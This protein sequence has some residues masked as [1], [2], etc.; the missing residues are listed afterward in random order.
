MGYAWVSANRHCGFQN[1]EKLKF[2]SIYSIYRRNI[3]RLKN[4]SVS[5]ICTSWEYVFIL[6][7]IMLPRTG[8]VVASAFHTH[9]KNFGIVLLLWFDNVIATQRQTVSFDT[10]AIQRT[11]KRTVLS[12][13]ARE[14]VWNSSS[15][16]INGFNI[17]W[18][19]ACTIHVG[20]SCCCNSGI[21]RNVTILLTSGRY[22]NKL[23]T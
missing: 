15:R 1:S 2:Q 6:W 9:I 14:S 17:Y 13:L 21:S 19:R 16:S 3:D 18:G 23:S 11:G 8:C 22:F 10:Y 12:Q 7:V 5:I 4:G 20:S